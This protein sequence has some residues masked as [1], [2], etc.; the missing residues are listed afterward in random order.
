MLSPGGHTDTSGSQSSASTFLCFLFASLWYWLLLLLFR[1]SFC[2]L[3]KVKV[4]LLS[5]VCL[6]A[7]WWTEARQ[8]P[9]SMGFSREEY[10]N[11]LPFPSPG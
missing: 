4:E 3:V 10:W 2:L 8:A 9:P 7:T 6:F 5:R 11:G 1:F